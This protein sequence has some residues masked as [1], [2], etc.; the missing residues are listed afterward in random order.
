MPKS[1]FAPK[2]RVFGVFEAVYRSSG[3]VREVASQVRASKVPVHA[4]RVLMRVTEVPIR[5]TQAPVHK[6]KVLA[7]A[8]K[9]AVHASQRWKP[10]ETFALASPQ[11]FTGLKP[12]YE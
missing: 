9:A 5:A 12:R 3:L 10:F 1:I 11:R 4:T 6:N 8:S 2:A 7:H